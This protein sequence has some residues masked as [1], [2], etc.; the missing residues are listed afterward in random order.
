MS[1]VADEMRE[2]QSF[3]EKYGLREDW[4]EPDEQSVTARVIGYQL[5]NAF[6]N[7]P[8]SIDCGDGVKEQHE[9]L[10]IIKHRDQ[11]G[12]DDTVVVN[13]ATLLAAGV[14]LNNRMS[15]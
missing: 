1:Y 3:A 6:G 11:Y 15:R 13:L 12:I 5:D 7:M 2:L 4:H 10:V 8:Y 9:I 14:E